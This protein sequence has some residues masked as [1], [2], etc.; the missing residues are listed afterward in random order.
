LAAVEIARGLSALGFLI[1]LKM[2][3][4]IAMT[5]AAVPNIKYNVKREDQVLTVGGT[6]MLSCNFTGRS[7]LNKNRG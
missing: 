7:Q 4:E 3:N 1:R 5:A 6:I 2:K